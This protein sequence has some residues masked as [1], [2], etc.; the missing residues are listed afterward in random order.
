LLASAGKAVTLC[1]FDGGT[2]ASH[3][4]RVV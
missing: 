2:G 4:K 1:D 3:R